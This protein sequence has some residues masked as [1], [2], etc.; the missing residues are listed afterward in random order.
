[1][2]QVKIFL[3]TS[4]IFTLINSFSAY[5]AENICENFFIELTKI[6]TNNT[7]VSK[8]VLD[9]IGLT[10]GTTLGRKYTVKDGWSGITKDGY[11]IITAL[12]PGTEGEIALRK[13][14]IIIE[15]DGVDLKKFPEDMTALESWY[16]FLGQKVDLLIKRND[17]IEDKLIEL[18]LDVNTPDIDVLLIPELKILDITEIN[19][20]KGTYSINYEF[21]Y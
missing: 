17:G 18:T 5:S 6:N 10:P 16:Y 11:P 1:M 21:N 3:L 8:R 15:L 20:K 12:I 7:I 2:K 9:G 13:N 19:A 4:I 14:D